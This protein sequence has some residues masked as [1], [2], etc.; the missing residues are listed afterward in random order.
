MSVRTDFLESAL[1]ATS[2]GLGLL[3]VCFDL[4]PLAVDALLLG[5]AFQFELHV[6]RFLPVFAVWKLN[7][8][9]PLFSKEVISFLF[10]RFRHLVVT[11][12]DNVGLHLSPLG[13]ERRLLAELGT[14]G[15]VPLSFEQGNLPVEFVVRQS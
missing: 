7:C 13:V 8:L 15:L 2:L 6:V 1:S 3:E 14:H 11:R 9:V 12:V 4:E 5:L 10:S